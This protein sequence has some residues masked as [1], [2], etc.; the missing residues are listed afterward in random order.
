MRLIQEQYGMS[1]HAESAM[2]DHDGVLGNKYALLTQRIRVQ[3]GITSS[4]ICRPCNEKYE[5]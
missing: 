1:V 5:S 2:Q 3:D 4:T